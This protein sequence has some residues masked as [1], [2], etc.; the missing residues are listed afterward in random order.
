MV[1]LHDKL[2]TEY[3][4]ISNCKFKNQGRMK[5]QFCDQHGQNKFI[6]IFKKSNLRNCL[7]DLHVLCSMYM[8][9]HEL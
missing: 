8:N 6:A 9:K 2:K 4:R 5:R 3:L 1:N 7:S